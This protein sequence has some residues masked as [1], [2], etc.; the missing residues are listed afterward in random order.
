MQHAARCNPEDAAH[1]VGV[2][3][4]S[5]TSNPRDHLVEQAHGVAH[6]AGRLTSN[7]TY[8]SVV[9]SHLFRIQDHTQAVRD[10]AGRYQLEV[11]ALA[12]AQ[13]GDGNLV[14]LGRRKDELHVGWRLF[15]GL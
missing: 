15:D 9:R 10:V 7:D 4:V 1:A 12:A 6:A 11:V 3:L 13:Y 2:E 5:A 8:G 14:R